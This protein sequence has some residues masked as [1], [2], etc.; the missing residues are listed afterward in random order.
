MVIRGGHRWLGLGL[1]VLGCTGLGTPCLA[2][3]ESKRMEPHR[4]GRGEEALVL[5]VETGKPVLVAVTSTAKPQVRTLWG[6]LLEDPRAREWAEGMVFVELLLEDEPALVHRLGLE[7]RPSLAV[8]RRR[9]QTVEKLLQRP[10]PDDLTELV[11][12]VGWLARSESAAMLPAADRDL[13]PTSYGSPL[14]T[15]AT[16]QTPPSFATGS[17]QGPLLAASPQAVAGS[18]AATLPSSPPHT[19]ALA[20]PTVYLQQASPTIVIGPTPPPTVLFASGPPWSPGGGAQAVGAT[21]QSDGLSPS[22]PTTPPFATT[23]V[24]PSQGP[25]VMGLVLKNPNLLDRLIG[26]LGRILAQRGSPRLL[27][28]HQP[29][30]LDQPLLVPASPFIPV[31]AAPAA[32]P[33]QFMTPPAAAPPGPA[34]AGLVASPQAAIPSGSPH[35]RSPT[36]GFLRSWLGPRR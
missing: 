31:V 34:A 24:I 23:T 36:S 27:V 5:A 2:E 20:S 25:V 21:P 7:G 14:Q 11:E 12:W 33:R 3:G 16:P 9:S 32:S 15:V 28:N 18:S 22:V 30:A 13:R 4:L 29:A 17:P 35:P 19:L 8:L 10:F 1:V 26:A 6:A